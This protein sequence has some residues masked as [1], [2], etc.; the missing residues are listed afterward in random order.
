MPFTALCAIARNKNYSLLTAHLAGGPYDSYDYTYP[1][2]TVVHT[3]I[4]EGSH[5][6]GKRITRRL[7]C[8]SREKKER[9]KEKKKEF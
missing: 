4:W 2:I 3:P 6:S 5:E 8:A 7:R 9:K 1:I